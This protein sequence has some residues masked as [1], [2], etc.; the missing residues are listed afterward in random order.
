MI[1]FNKWYNP[2]AELMQCL[3]CGAL[4]ADTELHTKWHERWN[5]LTSFYEDRMC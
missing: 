1:E 4:V 2:G 5:Y 3:D